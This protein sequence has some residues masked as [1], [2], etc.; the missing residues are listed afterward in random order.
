MS[1]MAE[2]SAQIDE[3]VEQGMS[4]KFISVSLGI[5]FEWAEQAVYD[6]E[7]LELEKQNVMMSYGD[8]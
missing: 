8:E 6:R 4:A 5:P 3:L 1:K 2:L 7:L